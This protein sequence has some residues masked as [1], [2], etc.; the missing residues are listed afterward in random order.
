[1][2]LDL[3]P[4][5]LR[6]FPDLD[7]SLLT[8]VVWAVGMGLLTGV[9]AVAKH[10]TFLESA[11]RLKYLLT[12]LAGV[13]AFHAMAGVRAAQLIAVAVAVA[14]VLMWLLARTLPPRAHDDEE[15][16]DSR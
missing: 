13:G 1:M 12:V 5:D 15:P 2:A 8:L 3:R 10:T 16:V 11:A 9:L 14:F 4:L 6:P 7:T